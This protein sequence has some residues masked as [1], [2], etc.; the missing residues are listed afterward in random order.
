[1]SYESIVN[2]ANTALMR[3]FGKTVAVGGVDVTAIM[4]TT[5]ESVQMLPND[6]RKPGVSL[7]LTET[8]CAQVA[9]DSGTEVIDGSNAYV[10]TNREPP[11]DGLVQIK[12]R[13]KPG[14]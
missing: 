5:P 14:T 2:R 9:T 4:A 8:V 6:A 13:K 10:I 3:K 1:M 11:I 12:L 7:W